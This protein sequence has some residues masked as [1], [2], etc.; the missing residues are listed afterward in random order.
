MNQ[1]ITRVRES[2]HKE[3]MML[4]IIEGKKSFS[5]VL[6][7]LLEEYKKTKEEK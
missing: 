5:E 7:M 4:K 6:R 3:I 2:E 1:V